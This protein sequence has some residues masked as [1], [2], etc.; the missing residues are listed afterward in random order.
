M[1]QSQT[2]Q[3]SC[4][5]PI[6]SEACDSNQGVGKPTDAQRKAIFTPL[7]AYNAAMVGD[8]RLE[9]L[10]LLLE[11]LEKGEIIGGL[12]GKSFHDWLFIEL[13]FVP[14]DLRERGF[15]AN[16]MA[17]AES[18]ARDRQCVGIWLDTHSFQA[19]VFYKKLGYEVFGSL[20]DYFCPGRPPF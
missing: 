17:R 5:R 3:Q 11:D 10:A 1:R 4:N 9:T 15:G 18:A 12:W 6:W 2:C 20:D 8:P 19:P 13:L 16:L 7:V 14:E